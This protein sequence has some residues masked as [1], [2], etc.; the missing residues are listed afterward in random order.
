MT[1]TK[2]TQTE[3]ILQFIKENGSITR[4]QAA[5]EVGAFELSARIVELERAGHVFMKEHVKVKNRYGD[6][7]RVVRY[8]LFGE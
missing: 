7:V 8:S 4:L 5:N 3:R 1:D 2:P 6:S